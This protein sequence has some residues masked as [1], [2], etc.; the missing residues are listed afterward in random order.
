MVAGVPE[1]FGDHLDELTGGQQQRR[2]GVPQI[3]QPDPR[4]LVLPQ[5]PSAPGHMCDAGSDI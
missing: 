2:V 4:Q 5:G 3:L 1:P